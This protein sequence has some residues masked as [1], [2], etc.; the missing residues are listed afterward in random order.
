MLSPRRLGGALFAAVLVGSMM[1]GPAWSATA[2]TPGA[3]TGTRAYEVTLVTGD[4][5]MVST[6]GSVTVIPD[7]SRR[8]IQFTTY[9]DESGHVHV[10]PFDAA[11]LVSTGAVDG[12]L[13]DVTAL[14]GYGFNTRSGGLPLIVKGAKSRAPAARGL[15]TKS[16]VTIKRELSSVDGAAIRS[17]HAKATAFWNQMTTGSGIDR[18]LRNE[19]NG[20]WLDRPL[21]VSLDQSVPKVGAP[22]AWAAGYDG[23]GVTVAVLDSGID[24]THP[25]L[26]GKVAASANFT[27]EPTTEDMLGHGTHVASIVAGSGTASGGAYRGVAPGAK[28]LNGKVCIA[29]RSCAESSIIAGMEWAAQQDADVVNLSL[30]GPDTAGVDPMEE[31]V[32]TLTAAHGTLFVISSGNNQGEYSVSSPSTADAALSVGAVDDADQ[33]A[34]FS[35]TGPRIGDYA[36]KPDMTAPGSDIHAARSSTGW[37]GEAGQQYMDLSGTS[38]AAPHVAGAA[39]ILVQRRPTW[40]PAQLKAALMGSAA[41]NPAAPTFYQ[42]AGR[43]DIARGYQQTILADPP[44][45]SLGRQVWPHGDD[46][47]LTRTVTYTNTGSTAAALNLSL[48]TRAPNGSPAPG[49]MFTLNATSLSVGPGASAQV[50]LT[51]KTSVT[52][53]DGLYGGQITATGAGGVQITTPFAVDRGGEEYAV[54]TTNINRN[55]VADNLYVTYMFPLEPGLPMY[56][57]AFIGGPVTRMVKKGSYMVQTTI[58]DT[59]ATGGRLSLMINPRLEVTVDRSLTF[60]ARTAGQAN[61][62]ISNDA[63]EQ[64]FSYEI[65]FQMI[66]E[67]YTFGSGNLVTPDPTTTVYFGQSNPNQ[68]ESGYLGKV[69]ATLVRPGAAGD[70]RNPPASYRLAK[71]YPGNMP[72]GWAQTFTTGA[73]ARVDATMARDVPG[74]AAFKGAFAYPGTGAY[75]VSMQAA[76]AFDPPFTHVEY[77]NTGS[78]LRWL[79]TFSEQTGPDSVTV[80]EL[81]SG[82]NDYVPG[83]TV[84]ESWN[85]PVY[86]PSHGMAADPAKWVVRQGNT[87]FADVHLFGDGAGHPGQPVGLTTGQKVL[88]RNGVVVATRDYPSALNEGFDVASGYATY[89]LTVTADRA[90]P[91]ELST[92]VETVWTFKSDTVSGTYPVRMP[93]WD[94]SFRPN[95]NASNAAPAGVVFTIPATVTVQPNSTA[96]GLSTVTV[97]YSTDDGATWTSAVVSGSG[98]A[99]TVTLTHPHITGFVSLR[100]VVTDYA[101]NG[102]QQTIIRAYKIAQ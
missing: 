88:E 20:L 56:S 77:Y 64:P 53:P 3:S 29:D 86:G 66:Y 65:S 55:G 11:G 4:R 30:G 17:G 96:A 44:G 61:L 99:R 5:V 15:L 47:V 58:F 68:W 84:A 73:L 98:T 91:V 63:L 72:S 79:S 12:T 43:L 2:G 37:L 67:G 34:S 26:A 14:N 8:T 9:R 18:R 54:T 89:R 31:A 21:Q 7:P 32:N 41:A 57:W 38:M 69:A 92:R 13:F 82:L 71:Y 76:L 23:T 45:V 33:M 102:V 50:T 42:G 19:I 97:Q 74:A 1:S 75:G 49:G 85:R 10:I 16:G 70:F 94:V 90:A 46:P 81:Q 80:V 95:L 62:S 83:T 59:D 27:S 51:A 39:A 93:I 100:A 101:G 52:G 35:N 28:L 78:N 24:T 22:T 6:T 25:D 36:L 87:I 48:A 60:D 40:T